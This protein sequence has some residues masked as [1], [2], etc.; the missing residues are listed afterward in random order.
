[1]AEKNRTT[2]WVSLIQSCGMF[3]DNTT[4]SEDGLQTNL[5]A[6]Y[7]TSTT[8]LDRGRVFLID[9]QNKRNCLKQKYLKETMF[10]NCSNLPLKR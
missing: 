4:L 2:T 9:S 6:I 1:M 5:S 7:Q 10:R 8:R 3:V